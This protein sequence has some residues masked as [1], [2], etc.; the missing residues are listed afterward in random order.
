MR[1][2]EIEENKRKIT[3]ARLDMAALLCYIPLL[4]GGG[5]VT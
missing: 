4:F 3:A 5:R 2:P 1:R